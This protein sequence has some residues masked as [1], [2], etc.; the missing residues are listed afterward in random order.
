MSYALA[1]HWSLGVDGRASAATFSNQDLSISLAPA[2]EFSVWPYEE[3]PR[4]GLRFR[5][6]AGVR[7]FNYEEVTLFG[8]TRETRGYHELEV[9]INQRQ[10]WGSVF[11]NVEGSHY[12]H[13][14]EKYRVSTGGFLSFRIVRGLNLRVNGRVAWIRD[15]LFLPAEDIP[16]EEILL[17]RRRLASNFDWDFGVGFSFQFGSIYNNV[18]NNRF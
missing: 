3:S 7:H 15:Q 2:L 13:D 11:A 1:G 18:V 16:D 6:R 5:Y 12:L 9:S 10:P 14:V 17:Q 4:R 8:Q